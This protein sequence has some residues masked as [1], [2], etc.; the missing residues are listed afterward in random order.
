MPVILL[1]E[2]DVA[3]VFI[4]R[5]ALAKLGY[6]CDVRV[7]GTVSEAKRFMLNEAEFENAHYFRRPDLIVSDFRLA[8]HTSLAFVQWLR[9]EPKFASIPVVMLSGAVSAM[10]PAL[11]VGLAVN[12]FFRKTADVSVLGAT[13]QPVLP[14]H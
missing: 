8:G 10:D 1:I 2:D 14:Q 4:F 11:F 12:S 9:A 7:V 5:R 13:L 6:N 3:D